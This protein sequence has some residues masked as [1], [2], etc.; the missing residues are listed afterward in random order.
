MYL[1]LQGDW[2][3]GGHCQSWERPGGDQTAGHPPQCWEQ[4]DCTVSRKVH[5]LYLLSSYA[6][7]CGFEMKQWFIL[8]I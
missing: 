2:E 5:S 4:H 8:I 7:V 6:A 3:D 1:P